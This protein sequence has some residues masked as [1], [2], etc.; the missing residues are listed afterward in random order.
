MGTRTLARIAAAVAGGAFA[1]AFSAPALADDHTTPV[2]LK[3]SHVDVKA[4]DF[5]SKKCD[6]AFADLEDDEDGWH[7]VLT[8][9]SGDLADVTFAL[10]FTDNSSNPVQVQ[11]GEA[12][13][14]HT[15]G[16][17][18]LW[19][20]APAGWTL[21]SGSAEAPTDALGSNSQFNLSHTCDGEPSDEPGPEP[22]PTPT[23]PAPE[24]TPS[25]DPSAPPVEST[26][27]PG[28]EEEPGLPV[29]GAQAGGMVVLGG[30]LLAAGI[31]MMT[32]RR[33]RNLA[34]LLQD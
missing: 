28:D 14:V 31:A 25:S 8:Q 29:T 27:Q 13:F 9:F 33:R 18:H 17:V 34:E 2:D 20:V 32:V 6:G 1:L 22:T 5:T 15:G 19:L 12:D 21:V 4:A 26:P 3:E 11:F 16:V 23:K 7:F 10:E 30:G 24:P